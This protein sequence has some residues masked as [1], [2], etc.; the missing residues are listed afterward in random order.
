MLEVEKLEHTEDDRLGGVWR[1]GNERAGEWSPAHHTK[2]IIEIPVA[3]PLPV[4]SY[5]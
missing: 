4:I 3:S 1:T 5:Q 2:H